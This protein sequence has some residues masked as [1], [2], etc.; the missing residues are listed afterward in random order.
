MTTTHSWITLRSM[1]M[2][3]TSTFLCNRLTLIPWGAP[4]AFDIVLRT[5]LRIKLGRLATSTGLYE[6]ISCTK[7]GMFMV[8]DSSSH[9]EKGNDQEGEQSQFFITRLIKIEEWKLALEQT[10][11]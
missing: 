7:L 6:M 10:T 11:T 8:P 1:A 2:A 9:G 3:V 4:L 5:E